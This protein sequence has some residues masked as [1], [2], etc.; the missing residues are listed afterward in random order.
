M[1][2][3]QSQYLLWPPLACSTART[4]QQPKNATSGYFTWE[5]GPWQ[6]EK[7]HQMS[8]VSD[9]YRHRVRN[10]LRKIGLRAWRPYFGAVLRRRHRLPRVRWCNRVWDWDLQNW[11]RVWFSDESRFMLQKRDGRTRVYRRR[12]ARF[13][14][15]CVLQVD[16]FVRGSVMMWGAISYAW[17]TKLV[18]IPGNLSAARLQRWSFNTTH[19]SRN[20]PP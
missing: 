3:L 9:E 13:A 7:Q 1:T 5:T 12:N 18:R 17:K 16:N 19:A 15:N 20:E 14:R 4:H 2:S 11:R 8:Q 10:R 6:Q